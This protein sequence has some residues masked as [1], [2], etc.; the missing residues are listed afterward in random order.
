MAQVN[1]AIKP[2][3]F[4]GIGLD[5]T[6]YLKWAQSLNDYFEEKWC[7]GEESFMIATQKL[8]GYTQY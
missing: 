8:Q 4:D 1:K 3:Y 2:P 7:L 5:P 6:I